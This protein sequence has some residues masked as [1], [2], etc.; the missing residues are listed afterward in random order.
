MLRGAGYDVVRLTAS[1]FSDNGGFPADFS[2]SGVLDCLAVAPYT[3]V[4]PERIYTLARAVEY[5]VR[6][7]VPG[8]FVECGT[9]LGG[10]CM[11]M[12]RTL[13]RLG[14]TNRNL[15]LFDLFANNWPAATEHDSFH[16]KHVAELLEQGLVDVDAMNYTLDQVRENMRK[17]GYPEERVHYVMGRVEDTLPAQAPDTIAL[18]RLDTDFYE[19]TLHEWTHLY[20][21][22]SIGGVAIVDDYGEWAGSRKATDEFLAAQEAPLLLVRTDVAA[23]MGVRLR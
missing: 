7:D 16:G 22:L 1:P 2:Q 3:F 10:C 12:A 13:L 4:P 6:H 21:R 19:S 5:I 8:A 20:P 18:M 23:R 14:V 17:T 11:V 9:W 15:Y